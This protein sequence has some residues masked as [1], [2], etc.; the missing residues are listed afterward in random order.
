MEAVENKAETVTVVVRVRPL[1]SKER[2]NK[3][4]EALILDEG[5][6]EI[7]ILKGGDPWTFDRVF[8]TTTEQDLFFKVRR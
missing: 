1:S 8:G 6:N 7:G 3:E 2:G 4:E 5:R